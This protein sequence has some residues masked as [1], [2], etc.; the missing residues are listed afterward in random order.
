VN[1]PDPKGFLD[2]AAVW[3]ASRIADMGSMEKAAA[4]FPAHT[5]PGAVIA[6]VRKGVDPRL[7]PETTAYG[8]VGKKGVEAIVAAAEKLECGRHMGMAARVAAGAAMPVAAVVLALAFVDLPHLFG[9]LFGRDY[10]SLG[11]LAPVVSLLAVGISVERRYRRIVNGERNHNR[12]AVEKGRRAI[13][14]ATAAACMLAYM[15]VFYAKPLGLPI[16][17]SQ[18]AATSLPA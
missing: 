8:A 10:S 7:N 1:H 12:K 5:M 11:Q 15:T 14:V 3:C 18:L 17:F 9:G 2:N 13:R 16:R 4:S 6:D